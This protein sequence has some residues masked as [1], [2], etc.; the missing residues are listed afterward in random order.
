MFRRTIYRR[1]D[2]LT[3]WLAAA[4]RGSATLLLLVLAGCAFPVSL[5]MASLA[6]LSGTQDEPIVTGSS[7][8][9]VEEEGLSERLGAAQWAAL[10][11]AIAR[12]VEASE[13]GESFVWRNASGGTGTVVPISAY[14]GAAGEVCRRLAITA[15]EPEVVDVIMAEA[16]REEDRRWR[17]IPT[18]RQA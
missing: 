17:V 14:L 10:R 11:P 2:G 9:R 6:G 1:Q 8:A 12:A 18:P 15:S 16:C 3:R 13:D 5:P 7:G 4:A